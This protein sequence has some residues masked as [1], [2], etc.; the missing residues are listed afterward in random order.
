MIHPLKAT[1]NSLKMIITF[2]KAR[3]EGRSHLADFVPDLDKHLGSEILRQLVGNG[4]PLDEAG[5][6]ESLVQNSA[7]SRGCQAG[8][9][10]RQR[11]DI[12]MIRLTS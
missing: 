10:L 1:I 8:K 9:T 2:G 5:G 4:C 7:A 3:F 6:I 11:C 12:N